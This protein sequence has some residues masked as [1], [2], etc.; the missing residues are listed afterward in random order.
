MDFQTLSKPHQYHGFRGEV[1]MQRVIGNEVGESGELKPGLA[2][3]GTEN[4]T[5]TATVYMTG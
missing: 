2:I 3:I 1:D 5:Q 4:S